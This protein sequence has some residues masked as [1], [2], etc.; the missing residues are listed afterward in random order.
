MSVVSRAKRAKPPE[1]F[2]SPPGVTHRAAVSDLVRSGSGKSGRRTAAATP[3]STG[4]GGTSLIEIAMLLSIALLM[5]SGATTFYAS[6]VDAQRRNEEG[7][8]A[9]LREQQ[10]SPIDSAVRRGVDQAAGNTPAG[11]FRS[12]PLTPPAAGPS[13]GPVTGIQTSG[14]E[15]LR[16]TRESHAELLRLQEETRRAGEAVE[17]RLRELRARVPGQGTEAG[18][19]AT[20]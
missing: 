5:V 12:R 18:R 13:G 8:A 16:R 15:D 20:E 10:A 9:A 1:V 14:D 7:K 3:A 17:A 19:A 6:A 11:G 4:G 2:K